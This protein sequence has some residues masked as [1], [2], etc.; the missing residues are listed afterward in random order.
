MEKLFELMTVVTIDVQRELISVLPEV[1]ND[2]L[3]S[4]AAVKL[5]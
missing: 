3:H 2:R 4:E 1:L 5:R